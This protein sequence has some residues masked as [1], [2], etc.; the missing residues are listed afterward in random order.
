M[1]QEVLDALTELQNG[2]ESFYVPMDTIVEEVFA[3]KNAES[4]DLEPLRISVRKSLTQLT[5]NGILQKSGKLYTRSQLLP[6]TSD[7][8][9]NTVSFVEAALKFDCKLED[10][11]QRSKTER[12]R[13]KESL[14]SSDT[15][16]KSTD[17]AQKSIDTAQKSTPIQVMCTCCRRAIDTFYKTYQRLQRETR[18]QMFYAANPIDNAVHNLEPNLVKRCSCEP[19]LATFDATFLHNWTPPLCGQLQIGFF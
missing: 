7:G 4:L 13:E 19:F 6:E 15:E 11:P 14:A 9:Y 8:V 16:Q 5:R 10:L 17:T 12:L 2:Q 18:L 1:N 3:T